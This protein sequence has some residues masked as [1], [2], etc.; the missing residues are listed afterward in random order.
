[1]ESPEEFH[2]PDSSLKSDELEAS[3][4]SRGTTLRT[5]S[6][7]F[8]GSNQDNIY[9]ELE[10]A[11]RTMVE[12]HPVLSKLNEYLSGLAERPPTG[13]RQEPVFDMI[14]EFVATQQWIKFG[15]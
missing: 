13:C 5:R 2:S 3:P 7:S 15:Q 9:V 8:D 11:Q 6:L 12:M 1:M 4:G 14:R 10:H